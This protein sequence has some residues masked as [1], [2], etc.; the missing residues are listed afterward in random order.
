MKNSDFKLLGSCRPLKSSMAKMW[1]YAVQ[2][3]PSDKQCEASGDGTA[4]E[5]GAFPIW[6]SREDIIECKDPYVHTIVVRLGL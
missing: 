6:T 4:A 3:F 5:E 1:L 2:I